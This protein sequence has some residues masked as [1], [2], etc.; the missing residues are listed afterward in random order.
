MSYTTPPHLSALDRD[1]QYGPDRHLS[2]EHLDELR[3]ASASPSPI[4]LDAFRLC[5]VT[6][7]HVA[8]ALAVGVVS[9][10]E[11]HLRYIFKEF[12]PRS[13]GFLKKRSIRWLRLGPVTTQHGA[14]VLCVRI[15]REGLEARVNLGCSKIMISGQAITLILNATVPQTVLD[16]VVGEPVSRLVGHPL[17]GSPNYIVEEAVDLGGGKCCLVIRAGVVDQNVS[18]GGAP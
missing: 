6:I 7:D 3:H 4:L 11:H 1:A 9:K 5:R 17:L 14:L 16:A 2:S 18:I 8:A 13:V 10:G 12:S 15:G